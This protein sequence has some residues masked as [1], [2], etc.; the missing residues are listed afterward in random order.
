VTLAGPKKLSSPGPSGILDANAA[1]ERSMRPVLNV[2]SAKL[3]SSFASVA[4]LD[5]VIVATVRS[6][7]LVY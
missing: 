1:A 3:T 4:A 2:V 5:P 7:R 6:S